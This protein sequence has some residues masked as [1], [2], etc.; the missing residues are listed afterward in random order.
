M[1]KGSTV[2][3]AEQTD[4]LLIELH[5]FC[6]KEAGKQYRAADRGVSS[7]VSSMFYSTSYFPMTAAIGLEHLVSEHKELSLVII[8]S[9]VEDGF[10]LTRQSRWLERSCLLLSCRDHSSLSCDKSKAFALVRDQSLD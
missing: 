5:V 9:G 6:W 10:G 8:V 1:S 4:R 2:L 7:V 3:R